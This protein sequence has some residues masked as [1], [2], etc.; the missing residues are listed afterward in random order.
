MSEYDLLKSFE[1]G[2]EINR[3]LVVTNTSLKSRLVHAGSEFF[4]FL[5]VTQKS[6]TVEINQHAENLRGKLPRRESLS[7]ISE[8]GTDAI[9]EVIT[10]LFDLI[11]LVNQEYFSAK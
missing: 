10:A 4:N 1:L 5:D 7:S 3:I 11:Y 8:L 2:R 9:D 6:P